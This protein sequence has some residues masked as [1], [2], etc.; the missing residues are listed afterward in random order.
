M[1]AAPTPPL[2]DVQVPLPRAGAAQVPDDLI[3]ADRLRAWGTKSVYSLMDQALTSLTGFC[4]SFL[5]ARWMAP[6]VYGAYAIAFAAFLFVCGFHNVTVLEPM[7]VIGP[8]RHPGNLS[9]YFRS[10]IAVHAILASLLAALVVFAGLIVWRIEPQSPLVGAI[11]GSG[12]ALPFLLLLWLARRICYLLRRPLDA[13]LGSGSCL[14]FVFLG[15]YMLRHFGQLN[16]SSAFLLMGGGSLFGSYL[17]LRRIGLGTPRSI[18]GA[19]LSWKS[20]LKENWLYGRWLAGSTVFYSVAG[21]VQMFLAAAFLGLGAAGIL[22]ATLLP[23]SVMTQVVTAAGLLLLPGLAYDFGRGATARLRQKAVLASFALGGAGLAFVALLAVVAGPVE[24]LL[25]AGKYA[26]YAW[27]MPILAF[28]P[29]AN[30]FTMG[31]STALRA[32]QK[33]HF[34]LLANAIA[35]PIAVVSALLFIHWW[36][37]AG[38]AAS[39]VTGFA[40]SM[41]VNC[42]IFYTSPQPGREALNDPDLAK[43]R[44]T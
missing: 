12:L 13:V 30:G 38:A 44:C 34:D 31:Y 32:S 5:L 14:L 18:S 22:R 35:A 26:G 7:S 10:Q 25:F 17:V 39:M 21:Q 28:I 29:T 6:D 19:P 43:Q 41:V 16:P 27:L 36:G 3:T 42:W 15:L 20:V 37:L 1:S 11:L 23:A 2:T 33:P 4:V 8:A 24:H 40:V 9:R